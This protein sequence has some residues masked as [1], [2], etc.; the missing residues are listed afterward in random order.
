MDTERA[1]L[2]FVLLSSGATAFLV[3]RDGRSPFHKFLCSQ[4]PLVTR[5]FKRHKSV[6]AIPLRMEIELLRF[7]LDQRGTKAGKRILEFM[8]LPCYARADD[9]TQAGTV[10]TTPLHQAAMAFR[11]DIVYPLLTSGSLVMVRDDLLRTPIQVV[12]RAGKQRE[13]HLQAARIETIKRLLAAG[14]SILEAEQGGLTPVAIA[15]A[16]DDYDLMMVFAE[17]WQVVRR[18]IDSGVPK[19]PDWYIA[20]RARF[21]KQRL[22]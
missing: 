22:W 9:R 21:I 20:L 6:M 4:N 2:I 11:Y 19:E 8:K 18:V 14:A 13:P 7:A 10:I 3:D 1:D 15:L 16:E 12:C 17:Y 5:Q